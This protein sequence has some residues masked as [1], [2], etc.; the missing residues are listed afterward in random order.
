MVGEEEECVYPLGLD[1]L[2]C[3]GEE[4]GCILEWAYAVETLA[5]VWHGRWSNAYTLLG[6]M[7]ER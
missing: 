6:A 7:G 1:E 3:A 2:A 4:V 5:R